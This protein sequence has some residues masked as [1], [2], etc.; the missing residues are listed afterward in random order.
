MTMQQYEKVFKPILDTSKY[1]LQHTSTLPKKEY[2]L[3]TK[4]DTNKLYDLIME[5]LKDI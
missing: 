5:L 4:Y 1:I 3:I 2:L